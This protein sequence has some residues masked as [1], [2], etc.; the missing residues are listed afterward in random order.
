MMS[1]F[2]KDWV[3]CRENGKKE[4]VSLPHDAMLTEIGVLPMLLQ[5]GAGMDTK[6]V[7]QRLK[8]MQMHPR[9]RFIWIINSLEDN[10]YSDR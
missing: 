2:N 7:R 6:G 10:D 4:T 9:W 3:F 1:D 8:C 5:A